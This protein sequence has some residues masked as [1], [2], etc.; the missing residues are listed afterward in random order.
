M[1]IKPEKYFGEDFQFDVAIDP[2]DLILILFLTR[3]TAYTDNEIGFKG[4][5]EKLV[6]RL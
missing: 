4:P 2:L 6:S 5:K 3:Q 1:N